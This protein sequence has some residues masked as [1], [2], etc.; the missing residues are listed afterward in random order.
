MSD[1]AIILFAH[2]ARDPHWAAAF[3]II[4]QRLQAARPQIEVVVAFLEFMAPSL[5]AAVAQLVAQGAKSIVVAPLFMAKGGHLKRDLPLALERIRRQH[6][7]LELHV[8]P[9]I[10]DVPEI[11]QAIADW[12]LHAASA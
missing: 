2:G 10:G 7:Q 12:V 4:Q 8:L 11:L 3:D 5:E 1:Q 9:A 6:P